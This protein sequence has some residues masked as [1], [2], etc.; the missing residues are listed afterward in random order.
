MP[1]SAEEWRALQEE[2][3]A[4][5]DAFTEEWEQS[6]RAQMDYG[7]SEKANAAQAWAKRHGFTLKVWDESKHPRGG[8]P[9]HPSRFSEGEGATKPAEKPEA[10]PERYPSFPGAPGARTPQQATRPHPGPA[11][12]GAPGTHKPPSAAGR[13]P[14][15]K[16]LEQARMKR[17]DKL[18]S[19][20][21]EAFL[22][23]LEDGTQ[24]VFKPQEGEAPHIRDG[25]PAKTGYRREVA[26]SR[27]ADI[28]GFSDL[29]P[30]TTFREQGEQGVGSMQ[31]YA[32]D[33]PDAADVD[34]GE[35]FDG[36][37]DAARAA[38][39]DYLLGH[40]DRHQGNWLVKGGKLVLIDNGTSLPTDYSETDLFN[41]EF[42]RHAVKHELELPP[43]DDWADKWSEIE[44]E[45]KECGIEE[46]AIKLARKRFDSLVNAESPRFS[47]LPGFFEKWNMGE[48]VSAY[49]W[50]QRFRGAP[51]FTQDLENRS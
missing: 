12:E 47:D 23:T 40:L 51:G 4:E 17:A 26:A 10:K 6:L 50:G 48:I 46:P 29:V 45:M 32:E 19:G 20:T 35:R 3:G 49:D 34:K 33:A 14:A 31:A 16:S 24:G 13:S 1:L 2:F 15:H 36:P 7:D 22:L 41:M 44:K 43:M 30:T 37:E 28:L 39:F 27:I 8:D 5:L 9:K 42:W 11:P 18:S 25:V 38:A 21:N